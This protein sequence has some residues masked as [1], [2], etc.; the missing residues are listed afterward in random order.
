MSSILGADNT[1]NLLKKALDASSLRQK[2]ISNNVANINTPN[3]KAKRVVFE[4]EL[5]KQMTAGGNI[6]LKLTNDRH[7]GIQ[8]GSRGV[9]P[10]IV[11][12][13]T[14]SMRSD[15]NNVDIDLE[16][17]NLASN[18]L[19][20]NTLIQQTNNKISTLRHVIQEGKG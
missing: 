13:R 15:G 7:I 12:D 5:R 4:E 19:L 6:R 20:Y 8:S 3:Y 17:S 10:R 9:E 18:Q 14:N 2:A 16:M 11:E 1:Y